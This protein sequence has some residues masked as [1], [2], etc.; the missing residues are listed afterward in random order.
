MRVYACV[1]IVRVW[2]CVIYVLS[3]WCIRIFVAAASW[4]EV[5]F[6]SYSI[7]VWVR[8][9]A[10]ECWSKCLWCES[11]SSR[12]WSETQQGHLHR[13][14]VSN[15][16]MQMSFSVD[17]VRERV[18]WP[19]RARLK[20]PLSTWMT[21]QFFRRRADPSCLTASVCVLSVSLCWA[22]SHLVTSASR[23]S[24]ARTCCTQACCRHEGLAHIEHVGIC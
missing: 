9:C 18:F 20:R 17:Y 4:S 3:A 8:K 23:S 19:L 2:G 10:M 11:V 21:F 13:T 5:F 15:M 6:F 14:T 1:F 16:H 12:A 7:F 24:L 22:A